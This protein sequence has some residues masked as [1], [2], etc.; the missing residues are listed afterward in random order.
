MD[1]F[2]GKNVPTPDPVT[3]D[4][5][6]NKKSTKVAPDQKDQFMPANKITNKPT[7]PAATST[8]PIRKSESKPKK[9]FG[10]EKRSVVAVAS[11]ALFFMLS[12]AGVLVALRQQMAPEKVAAPTAPKS[13][14]AAAVIIEPPAQTSC[15]LSFNIPEASPSPS[16]SVSPSPS[17]SVSPSPS[18][19]VSPSPS[20]SVSPSPS[21]SVSPSPSPSPTPP[22]YVC[23]S[24]CTANAQCESA[25][26]D[27]ICST[28]YG[29][30]C[31][32]DSNP[33]SAKCETKTNEYACDSSCE[34]NAQCQTASSNYICYNNN[35]RLDSN[36]SASNC[37]PGTTTVIGCNDSCV[38]NSDC[39]S[40]DQICYNNAC[41]LA[42][43]P[44]SSTCSITT[45]T[46]GGQPSLPVEL[47]ESGSN[48]I[49]D[50]LKAGLGVIGIGAVL[51][52]LL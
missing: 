20:P 27:Y 4:P 21:P 12:M 35:C 8:P 25:N 18:P 38:D 19:S 39:S 42:T 10:L 28:T 41:R 1:I 13:K 2:G 29:D 11:I 3:P 9:I 49:F 16:P 34:T 37:Q 33:S 15:T 14:P 50:W 48:I 30:K 5:V 23:N 40:S 32:L 51:L 17:P 31:R 7:K 52:L 36:P 22:T 24:D 43:N 45:A 46:K 47:P 44:T 6:Q 26:A